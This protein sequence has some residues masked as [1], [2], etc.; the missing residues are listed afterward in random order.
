MIGSNNPFHRV[1]PAARGKRRRQALLVEYGLVQSEIVI[2]GVC[3]AVLKYTGLV[4]ES[5]GE[6]SQSLCRI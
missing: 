4:D 1:A 6:I 5:D 2:L 3:S